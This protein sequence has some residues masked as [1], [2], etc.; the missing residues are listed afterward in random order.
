MFH[1]SA[2]LHLLSNFNCAPLGRTQIKQ[3]WIQYIKQ[4][5]QLCLVY[6]YYHRRDYP[7]CTADHARTRPGP[8]RVT[9]TRSSKWYKTIKDVR[10]NISLPRWRPVVLIYETLMDHSTPFGPDSPPDFIFDLE[11]FQNNLSK[12]FCSQNSLQI[13]HG[14]AKVNLTNYLLSLTPQTDHLA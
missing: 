8:C 14:C 2:P 3:R 7:L 11:Y 12:T 4:N 10:G 13:L 6:L 9:G 5:Y 1:S